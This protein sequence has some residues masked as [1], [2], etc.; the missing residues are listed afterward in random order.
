M[1]RQR[2]EGAIT[3]IRYIIKFGSAPGDLS[4]LPSL[5]HDRDQVTQAAPIAKRLLNL[6]KELANNMCTA[7]AYHGNIPWTCIHS[8][9]WMIPKGLPHNPNAL[10]SQEE[11][12]EDKDM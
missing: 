10:V 3:L 2:A 5:F 1:Q 6:A 12:F 8:T 4:E 11:F 9:P 7:G